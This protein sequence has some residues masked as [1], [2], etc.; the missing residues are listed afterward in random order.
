MLLAEG[1]RA[2][3]RA[4]LGRGI[5]LVESSRAD[6]QVLAQELLSLVLPETGNA[7][8][9]GISGAP[10]VGKSTFLESFGLFLIGQGL[11]FTAHCFVGA[12]PITFAIG[13][14]QCSI[15]LQELS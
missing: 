15:R 1:I 5:T 2:G 12:P 6:H 11:N 14:T 8:R 3:E 7:V 4:S 13:K 9:I 10:G